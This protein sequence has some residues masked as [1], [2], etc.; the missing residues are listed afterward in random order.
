M[1]L[2][3]MDLIF[4]NPTGDGMRRIQLVRRFRRVEIFDLMQHLAGHDLQETSSGPDLI[5]NKATVPKH[6]RLIR[7]EEKAKGTAIGSL[8][9]E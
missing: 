7:K 4:S 2:K 6:S 8:K 1:A 5:P 3:I 9:F